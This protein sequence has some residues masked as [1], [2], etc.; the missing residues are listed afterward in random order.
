[1]RPSNALRGGFLSETVSDL[2]TRFLAAYHLQRGR[3]R[4]G[5]T[6]QFDVVTN[7]YGILHIGRDMVGKIPVT[8][9]DSQPV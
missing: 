5:L 8:T 4:V 7:R 1:M 2:E 9:C 6:C 3:Q